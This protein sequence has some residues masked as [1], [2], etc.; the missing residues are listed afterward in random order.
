M[1]IV[2]IASNSYLPRAR[3]LGHSIK[4]HCPK[5][6]FSLILVD[7]EPEGFTHSRE[8]FDEVI[9]FQELGLSIKNFSQWLF[10][11][12]LFELSCA[13]K[14]KAV[15]TIIER[16]K[17][18]KVIW[19]DSDIALFSSLD[20]IETLLETYSIIV[21]PQI[22]EPE[23][24]TQAIIDNEINS[25]GYGL[26]NLGFLAVR[27]DETTYQF[28]LW[29]NERLMQFCHRDRE[30][31]LFVDQKWMNLAPVFFNNVYLLK[32]K[33]YNVS[34]WNISQ[35]ILKKEGNGAY[36]INGAPLRF[37]HFS[38]VYS[39]GLKERV[40][41]YA[42]GISVFYELLTW[43]TQQLK[44]YGQ[45]KYGALQWTY[46]FYS[47]G[48][49]IKYSHRLIYYKRN[50]LQ[51]MFPDPF[52][53]SDGNSFSAWC[54]SNP[55]QAEIDNPYYHELQSLLNSKSWRITAPFRVVNNFFKRVLT[56]FTR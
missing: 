1:H 17:A 36:S 56:L 9:Q 39:P 54:E 34:I 2:S 33:G 37:V 53:S 6:F 43:Y 13:L 47:N 28:L 5:A 25:L 7:R 41:Q 24:D 23:T 14:A 26:F 3:V 40:E 27:S 50:D 10:F 8:P 49:A 4:K 45:G 11:H 21:T 22:T 15:L 48:E 44:E 42:K 46:D 51:N 29:W 30:K 32:G 55:Y 38:S 31:G 16:H 52:D 19:L 35:R 12:D 20:D 18:D